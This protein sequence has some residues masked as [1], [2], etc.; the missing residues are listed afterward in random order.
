MMSLFEFLMIGP[1]GSN[2]KT[3]AATG[4]PG[5]PPR[6]IPA[7]WGHSG[8]TVVG[9]RHP[10]GLQAH[11]FQHCPVGQR[12]IC[13]IRLPSAWRWAAYLGGSP[14]EDA[15]EG[16]PGEVFPGRGDVPVSVVCTSWL[17]PLICC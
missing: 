17:P 7:L 9:S 10:D 15:C 6:T 12:F 3:G 16:N 14:P 11:R 1:F 13:G 2:G 5:K 4:L 8:A